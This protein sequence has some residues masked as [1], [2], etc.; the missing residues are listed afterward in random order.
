MKINLEERLYNLILKEKKLYRLETLCSNCRILCILTKE[1]NEKNI[2][3]RFWKKLDLEIR[4]DEE[5]N[6]LRHLVDLDLS[7][8]SKQVS[9][10]YCLWHILYSNNIR[11]KNSISYNQFK[12]IISKDKL[13]NEELEKIETIINTK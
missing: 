13:L 9:I 7:L 4:F 10:S 3:Y 12:N 1:E 11:V 8:D 5:E 6:P 2:L